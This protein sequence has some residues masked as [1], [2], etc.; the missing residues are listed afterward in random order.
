MLNFHLNLKGEREGGQTWP[1]RRSKMLLE[2]SHSRVRR[3]WGAGGRGGRAAEHNFWTFSKA[4]PCERR[5][6]GGRV[7]SGSSRLLYRG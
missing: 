7:G 4:A 2:D 5:A 6:I 1:R 3:G